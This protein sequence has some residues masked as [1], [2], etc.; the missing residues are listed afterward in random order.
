MINFRE[1]IDVLKVCNY[2]TKIENEKEIYFDVI[3]DE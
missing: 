1:F 3:F 2:T